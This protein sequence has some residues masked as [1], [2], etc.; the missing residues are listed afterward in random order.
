M[1]ASR[2][3][4]AEKVR[5]SAASRPARLPGVPYFDH[6]QVQPGRP[7]RRGGPLPRP[8]ARTGE[9]GLPGALVGRRVPARG[10]ARHPGYRRPPPCARGDAD[11]VEHGRSEAPGAADRRE[12]LP[13]RRHPDRRAPAAAGRLRSPSRRLSAERHAVRGARRARLPHPFEL[14][15]RG[16]RR[17]QR[18]Q[19]P[20]RI[21]APRG[22]HRGR[23]VRPARPAHGGDRAGVRPGSAG[24]GMDPDPGPAVAGERPLP[25]RLLR[26]RSRPGPHPGDC[27]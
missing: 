8:A 7:R 5:Q 19:R 9:P 10:L 2:G 18:V 16:G 14:G 24:D 25:P 20:G 12:R 4:A 22:L 23:G 11:P 15:E 21:L 27:P 1:S 6:A 17:R 26:H 13:D 3:A